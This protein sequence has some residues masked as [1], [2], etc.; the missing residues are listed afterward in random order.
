MKYK[1]ITEASVDMPKEFAEEKDITILPIEVNFNGELYP[2]GLPTKEFYE[3]LKTGII[4]KTSQPNQ[5]KFENAL[6]PYINK[7]DWFV[8]IVVISADLAGTIAQ[9]K[10]AVEN[11]GMKNV[12][13]C[14]SRVTTFA[15]GALIMEI[16]KFYIYILCI[17]SFINK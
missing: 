8:L 3:K 12:Y 9:A 1:I 2:E 6:N 4:P 13:I 14:D 16:Q 17:S 15:E 5:Y 11:L 10:N 7:E